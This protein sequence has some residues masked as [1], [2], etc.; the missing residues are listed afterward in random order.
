MD[1]SHSEALEIIRVITEDGSQQQS[2]GV[3]SSYHAGC[4]ALELLKEE[5]MKV[6]IVTFCA[7]IDNMLGGGVFPGKI[8]EFCGAPGVGKTQMRS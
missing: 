2:S 7:E 6:P 8:T 3:R 5:Q 1:I 4:S